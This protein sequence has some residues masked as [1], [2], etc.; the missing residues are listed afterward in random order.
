VTTTEP[1]RLLALEGAFNFRDLGGY[2]TADGRITRWRR[3]FR[4]DGPHALTP[5]DAEVLA[6]LGIVSIVDLRTADEAGQRGKWHVHVGNATYHHFPMLD[7]LPDEEELSGWDDP[8]RVGTHYLDMAA[9]ASDAIGATIRTLAQPASLPAMFHCSAGKDRTGV[10]AAL[11]LGLAGVPDDTIIA[12]YA[13]SREAMV[14]MLTWLRARVE[15]PEQLERYAPAVRAAEPEAMA[16]FL[17]GLRTQYGSFD[18][19]ASALAVDDVVDA[20]RAQLL[21]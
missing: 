1:S 19:F 5:A 10:L 18:A 20:L 6:G 16:V 21:D 15:D 9:R 17:A 11:L 8:I 12:D 2:A 7:V 4:A 3:L 14:R 13:L